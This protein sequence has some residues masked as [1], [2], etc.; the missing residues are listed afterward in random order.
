MNEIAEKPATT[1]G[2]IWMVL[3]PVALTWTAIIALMYPS[4]ASMVALWDG[5]ETYTHGY[6]IFPIFAWLVWRKRHE[7][8]Q[9]PARP[10]AWALLPVATLSLIWLAARLTGIQVVEQYAMVGLLPLTFWAL[11]GRRMVWLLFFPLAYLLFMVPTGDGLSQ[12]L[13]N[14]T[15]DFTVTV[16]RLLGLPVYREG[17]YFS[18]PTGDWNVVEE[19]SGIRYIVA[20][21]VLGWLYAYLSYRSW[22]KRLI[23]GLVCIAVPVIA[24]GFR[25]VMIVLIGHFSGMKLAVGVDH[26]IYG[27]VWFG[28]VIFTL[29]WVG[30]FWREDH[31]EVPVPHVASPGERSSS[32]RAI[33][34]MA[35]ATILLVAIM[36]FH[37][38]QLDDHPPA[39][40]P[41]DEI[42]DAGGWRMSDQ[43]ITSWA[44]LWQGMSDQRNMTLAD[45]A[46]K[47][48]LFVRWYGTQ[49]QGG[50]L[51][52]HAN[53]LIREINEIWRKPS[54][55]SRVVRLASGAGLPVREAVL[56]SPVTNQHLLVWYWNRVAGKSMTG[57]V[58]AKLTLAGRRLLG[59]P[60][61]GAAVI[62]AVPYAE[63]PDEARST[64]KRFAESF[65]PS[66]HEILDRGMR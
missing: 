20:T 48:A 55:T 49:S 30:N 65:A 6:V 18:L 22:W 62:L 37:G 47:V 27:W 45:S 58:E 42:A 8:A 61:A 53:V 9:T 59:K 38:R 43:P 44:P 40:S 57:D 3:A 51:N 15:A 2:R 1:G 19:C 35:A 66:L 41:L 12:P 56:D 11:L 17:P 32:P 13:I 54:D 33:W 36:P 52:S 21:L 23:F 29:F 63:H 39:P 25:A 34:F 24:N 7:L 5:S 4:L 28:V 14:F 10:D 50:E 60:D 16:L 26:F 46:G 31:L 64:L